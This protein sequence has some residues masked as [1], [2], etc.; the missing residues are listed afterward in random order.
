MKY[1][2]NNNYTE[3]KDKSC[4]IRPTKNFILREGKDVKSLRTQYQVI[5]YTTIKI[6]QKINKYQIDELELKSHPKRNSSKKQIFVEKP[7]IHIQ[8]PQ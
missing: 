5:N 6:N 3:I 8:G 7:K 4:F 1:L 2:N